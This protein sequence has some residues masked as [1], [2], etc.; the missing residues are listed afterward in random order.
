M[1]D[2]DFKHTTRAQHDRRVKAEAIAD[3]MVMTRCP[4]PRTPA[5]RS[6]IVQA[7]GYARASDETWDLALLL[8]HRP[9]AVVAITT[10]EV[11]AYATRLG[12]NCRQVIAFTP[13]R[14]SDR[15]NYGCQVRGVVYLHAWVGV[16][17]HL[18]DQRDEE[19]ARAVL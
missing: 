12:L 2:V 14:V 6:Q 13:E 9:L 19:L 4:E 8:R 7:A 18:V 3:L 11:D 15:A 1:A 5:Q 16:D 10:D 17:A